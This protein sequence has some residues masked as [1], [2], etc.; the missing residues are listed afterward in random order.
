MNI[1]IKALLAASALVIGTSQI[2]R[3]DEVT[4][5]LNSA[6][7]AYEEGDIQYALEELEFAKQLLVAMKTDAL[8]GFLPEPPA[9]YTREISSD[10]A[11]GMAMVG[12]GTGAEATY[13]N[14]SDRFTISIV[15]D[16]PMMAMMGG[17]V[18]NASAMGLQVV[19]VGREKFMLQD[20][21]VI[22]MI[23]G[24]V[25]VTGSGANTDLIVETLK[26]MDFKSL[27]N[28]GE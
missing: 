21:D 3:A 5:T 10:L 18:A 6:L 13:T 7:A 23:G 24:R 4:D 9:G 20:G 16:S 15:A 14:G 26:T 19:R 17:M 11:Q 27:K 28:F 12:G 8:A 2:A 25:M 1:S 22:G